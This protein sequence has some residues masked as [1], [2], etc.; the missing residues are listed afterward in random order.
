MRTLL[1]C[2][3]V[4][5]TAPAICTAEPFELK[6]G[7][8]VVWLGSTLI[9]REQ[10][11]G[12]W[13]TALTARWP[14]RNITFRNLGWSGDNVYGEARLAFDINKPELGLKRMVDLTLAEK[15]TVIFICYGTNESFEGEAG[16]ARFEKGYEKL[17]DELKPAK[18]RIVLF[19]P[20]P[21]ENSSSKLPDD[22]KKK[23][24]KN[25]AVYSNTIRA[26]AMK[27]EV[28]LVDLFKQFGGEQNGTMNVTDN[29]L[30]CTQYGYWITTDVIL[31]EMGLNTKPREYFYNRKWEFTGQNV[32]C[33]V[34]KKDPLT[35]D[36]TADFLPQPREPIGGPKEANVPIIIRPQPVKDN[37]PKGIPIE[38]LP[39]FD[40]RID[41]KP[42]DPWYIDFAGSPAENQ[43]WSAF[44]RQPSE[45]EQTEQLRQAIIEKNQLYFY[46]W[47]PQ[48]ETY[49][50]GFRK[51]EQGKNAKEVAEFDPLIAA[52]EKEIAKL[53]VPKTHRYEIVPVEKK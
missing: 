44:L 49:L 31:K 39:R 30:H 51:H 45:N 37:P 5:V 19:T 24:N 33:V 20:T 17:L 10:R 6:D 22:E 46:R 32:K 48:N 38:S 15:P 35:V 53:R 52:K 25:L 18:A 2:L 9:E 16:L 23:Q 34:V 42:V 50:F 21:V 14:D 8:K 4:F 41:G 12:Y 36:I 11:Y 3:S 26:I 27:R 28:K 29:G 47:R 7:D 43:L 13:E 1:V 40:V